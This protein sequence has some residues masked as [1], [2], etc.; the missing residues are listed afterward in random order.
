MEAEGSNRE[1][2][3][4]GGDPGIAVTAEKLRKSLRSYSCALLG[5]HLESPVS[6]LDIP[7]C[8]MVSMPSVRTPLDVDIQRLRAEF[9]EGYRRGNAAFIVSLSSVDLVEM[10]VTDDIRA[11]WTEMWQAEDDAFEERLQSNPE[12]QSFSKKM[13][14]VWDGNHRLRAWY[15]LI[16]EMHPD[17]WTFHVPV[18][19]TLVKVT[20]ENKLK[21]LSAMRDV[22]K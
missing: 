1:G 14:F 7:L 17:D 10:E 15:P 12:L 5:Q 13:F 16:N 18:R 6:E 3:D 19:C 4:R 11:E 8:R 9:T 21:L 22:N 2:R 20:R